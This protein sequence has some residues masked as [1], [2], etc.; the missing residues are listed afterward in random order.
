MKV[1]K[2]NR[3]IYV[4]ILPIPMFHEG[5]LKIIAFD[6]HTQL[7]LSYPFICATRRRKTE[8]A[9]TPPSLY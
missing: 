2:N 6:V 9:K 3:Y 8:L 5:K 7:I 1:R 4:Q